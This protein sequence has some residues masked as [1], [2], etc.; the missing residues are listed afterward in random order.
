MKHL[1][2]Y[3]RLALILALLLYVVY[4]VSALSGSRYDPSAQSTL[5]V[6]D[7]V[8]DTPVSD[9][10]FRL[11]KVAEV[12]EQLE[13]V[14][15]AGFQ[16]SGVSLSKDDSSWSA[17]ASTLEAYVVEQRAEGAEIPPVASGTTDSLGKVAFPD[18]PSGLYLLVGDGKTWGGSSYK[19]QPVLLTLPYQEDVASWTTEP[20]VYTKNAVRDLR[21]SPTE[22]SV[23]KVWKDSDYTDQRPQS[24]TVALYQDEAFYASVTLS[25]ENSWRYTWEELDSASD[26]YV[27]EQNV[28]SGYTVSVAQEGTHFVVTN[29]YT[30]PTETPSPTPTPTTPN[31]PTTSTPKTP[32]TTTTTTKLP[33]TGQLWWPVTILALSGLAM[34][35]LG[36]GIYRRGHD[37]EG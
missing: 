35:V 37:H 13:F 25:E 8:G 10:T 23:V 16:D 15:T 1:K 31:T 26:Y 3:R 28:P 21:E 33:Q 32:T 20:L 36:W 7:Q 12:T 14:E 19:S 4:P 34:L 22:I 5:T 18:L 24:V 2:R 27:V 6:V 17:Q 29:T 30:P 9:V 11:Y